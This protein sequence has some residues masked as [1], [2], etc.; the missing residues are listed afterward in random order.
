MQFS[1]FL[2]LRQ[3][4]WDEGEGGDYGG[5]RHFIEGEI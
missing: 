3:G 2:A 1:P 4:A 5:L